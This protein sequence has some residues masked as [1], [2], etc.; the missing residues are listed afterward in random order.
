MKSPCSFRELGFFYWKTNIDNYHDCTIFYVIFIYAT[1]FN[2][3]NRNFITF[4]ID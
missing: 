3:E 4:D 2:M 1:L